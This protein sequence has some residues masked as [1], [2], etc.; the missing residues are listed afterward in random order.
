MRIGIDVTML[1]VRQGRHGIGSYLR[2]LVGG[3]ARTAGHEYALLAWRAPALELPALPP[4]FRVI[5]LPTPAIGRGRALFT[6][7][8]ALPAVARRARLDLLHIPGVAVTASMPSAP[9]WPSVPVVLT[10]HDLIPL[11]FP[12]AV[13]PRRRHRVF[14]RLMLRAGERA[15]GIVCDSE[16]TRGDL[17]RRLGVPAARVSVAPLA[18]AAS[19]TPDPVAPENGRSRGLPADFVLHVGGPAPTKNLRGL[20]AAMSALWDRGLGDHLVS[21][22]SVPF[23]PASN[24]ARATLREK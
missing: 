9:L 16:H 19:F 1:Q 13:L 4:H 23:D 10:V 18:A 15:A 14:Y 5:A 12:D 6:H 17:I 24:S 11:L 2:G 7:Q 21:V 22:S 20:L 8:I 3:L